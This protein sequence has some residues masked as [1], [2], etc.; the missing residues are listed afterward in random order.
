MSCS[1]L[2]TQVWHMLTRNHTVLP[3]THMFINK[4][5]EPYMPLLSSRIASPHFCRY[6]F[7]IQ[8]RVGG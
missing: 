6:S 8:L 7:P 5:N 1:S 2:G 3:D 4:W